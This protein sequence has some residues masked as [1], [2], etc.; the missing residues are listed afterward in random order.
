MVQDIL[1]AVGHKPPDLS[2]AVLV[3][4]HKYTGP[5]F[6]PKCPFHPE[7]SNGSS[8]LSRQQIP[9]MLSYAITIHKSQGQTLSKAVIDIGD[10]LE[11]LLLP[12]PD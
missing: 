2:I 8:R 9:L 3:T 5:P 4:F 11:P 7:W 12:Y 10:L 6:K 1:Y